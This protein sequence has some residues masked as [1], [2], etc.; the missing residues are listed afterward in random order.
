M[1]RKKGKHNNLFHIFSVLF[2]SIIARAPNRLISHYVNH[3]LFS[4]LPSQNFTCDTL[5]NETTCYGVY[6]NMKNQKFKSYSQ[7]QVLPPTLNKLFSFKQGFKLLIKFFFVA[8]T[9]L[10]SS[11]LFL[12]S[13]GSPIK[14]AHCIIFW[15]TVLLDAICQY[16][17][18]QS[19]YLNTL[20]SSFH[21]LLLISGSAL[22]SLHLCAA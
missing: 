10:D 13:F 6:N 12:E 21:S 2:L 19:C 15:H 18:N 4:K 11:L 14:Y 7:Q 1:L 22:F 3:F 5:T 20:S 17:V 9:S 16:L 8:I